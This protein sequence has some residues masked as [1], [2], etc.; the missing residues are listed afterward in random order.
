MELE[1]EKLKEYISAVYKMEESVYKQSSALE[2]AKKILNRGPVYEEVTPGKKP[3]K[4][5][6]TEEAEKIVKPELKLSRFPVI[7]LCLTIFNVFAFLLVLLPSLSNKETRNIPL[8]IFY[9]ICLII[10]GY[11]FIDAEL[12][13]DK[14]YSDYN[15]K[16]EEYNNKLEEQKKAQ[17]EYDAEYQWQMNA[18]ERE[19]AKCKAENNKRHTVALHLFNEARTDVFKM[20]QTYKDSQNVLNKLYDLDVIYPKYRNI[21]AM[22]SINEYFESGRC[23]ELKGPNGAYNLY[24]QEVRM[25]LIIVSLGAILNNLNAIKQN[26]YCLFQTLTDAKREMHSINYSLNNLLDESR[27]Q[28]AIAEINAKENAVIAHNTKMIAFLDLYNTPI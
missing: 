17:P 6:A 12:T 1:G 21:V 14:E 23:T 7:S 2:E 25:N 27:R 22:A 13:R 19:K 11:V 26:Q 5:I 24:E 15:K 3:Q 20:K 16:L 8:F 10:T 28:S 9:L 18:Y 4:R